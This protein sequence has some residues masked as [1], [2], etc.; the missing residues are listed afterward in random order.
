MRKS[1]PY[2]LMLLSST[3]VAQMWTELEKDQII[4]YWAPANR[5]VTASTGK[6]GV[7]LT[8][9]GSKWL[10]EYNRLRGKAKS[11]P[12]LVPVATNPQEAVWEKWIDAR[13]AYDRWRAQP[14]ATVVQDPGPAPAELIELAGNPPPFASLVTPN[15]FVVNIDG[16]QYVYEDN[17]D[18]RPRFAYY[19]FTD[20]VRSFGTKLG[21]L[22]LPE[23]NAILDS[24][25]VDESGSRIFKAVSLLEG[26]FDSLNTYDT[27]FIS[28]GFIQFA[29]LA[30][31]GHSLGQSL[32]QF[33]TDN[34]IEFGKDFRRFGIDVNSAGL[35]VAL[36]TN[37]RTERVGGAANEL[38][39]KDKRLAAVFQR[40][41]QFKPYRVAQV[42]TA[43]RMYWPAKEKWSIKK[44][45]GEVIS[46]TLDE[47]IESEAAMAVFLDRKVNTGNLGFLNSV[48]QAIADEQQEYCI[49]VLKK[50]EGVVVEALWYRYNPNKDTILSKPKACEMLPAVM[51]KFKRS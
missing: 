14:L 39:I 6:P 13:V 30:E 22:P 31:G 11:N 5:L 44:P 2:L 12:G 7:R 42:K 27:G 47:I 45:S 38:V 10:W 46:G 3:S 23:L 9:E 25:G 33:K 24:A 35:I 32:L 49:D 1:L 15:K 17:L 34:P 37:T 28:V 21:T 26:G 18:M 29:A 48:L 8:V 40:A 36:D 51:S 4:K 50:F 19:R 20:G 43:K 16:Q 41:G